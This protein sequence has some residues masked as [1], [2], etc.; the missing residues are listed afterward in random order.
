MRRPRRFL[1]DYWLL[2]LFI[3]MIQPSCTDECPQFQSGRHRPQ[4]SFSIR[5]QER[6]MIFSRAV[7]FLILALV[8]VPD[9]QFFVC[10][11]EADALASSP[12]RV[13]RL[14]GRKLRPAVRRNVD[15]SSSFD[16]LSSR[17][18]PSRDGPSPSNDR[19]LQVVGVPRTNSPDS[20]NSPSVDDDPSPS[21]DDDASNKNHD[22]TI[23]Y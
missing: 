11:Q 22:S 9:P 2:G 5:Q 20:L 17:K 4:R 15:D 16:S 8:L 14:R 1:H 7:T 18:S 21:K 10:A 12:W 6:I 19:L 13:R 23:Y 3:I